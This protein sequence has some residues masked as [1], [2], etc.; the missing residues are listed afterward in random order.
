MGL[1]FQL[2]IEL[3]FC[4]VEKI[5]QSVNKKTNNFW[6]ISTFI[7]VLVAFKNFLLRKALEL[8]SALFVV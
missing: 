6:N 3:L 7:K 2:Q 1:G 8:S 5:Y 4:M